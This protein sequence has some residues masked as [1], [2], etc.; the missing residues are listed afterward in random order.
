M[1]TID[2]TKFAEMIKSKRGSRGLKEAAEEIGGVSVSTLSRIEQGSLPDIGTYFKICKWLDVSSDFFTVG[3]KD[4]RPTDVIV[5]AHLRADKTLS[6]PTAEALIQMIRLA[7]TNG[8][9]VKTQHK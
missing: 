2:T 9:V 7:F 5:E 8:A 3:N 6:K 1:S 4:E